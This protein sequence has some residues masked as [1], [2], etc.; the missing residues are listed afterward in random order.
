MSLGSI[1]IHIIIFTNSI[2][3]KLLLRHLVEEKLN[4]MQLQSPTVSCTALLCFCLYLVSRL[5]NKVLNLTFICISDL[6][7]VL[8]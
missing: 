8:K 2:R 5:A 6:G 7:I 3:T 4:W 1:G